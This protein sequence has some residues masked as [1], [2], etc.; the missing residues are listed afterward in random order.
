MEMEAYGDMVK[1][2]PFYGG[3]VGILLWIHIRENNLI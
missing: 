1:S 2:L 3:I